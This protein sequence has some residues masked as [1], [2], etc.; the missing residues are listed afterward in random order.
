[1]MNEEPKSIIKDKPLPPSKDFELLKKEGIR[2]SQQLSGAVWTDYNEHDPGVTI[3]ENLCYA[4][5]E[6]GYKTN[7]DI[8]DLLYAKSDN[9]LAN[10]NNV[11]F[12]VS[13]I[14]PCNPTTASDYRKLV[15]DR[16]AGVENAWF[17]PLQKSKTGISVNGLYEVL[18]RTEETADKEAVRQEVI[19]LLQEHRNLCEDFDD[20]RVLNSE[21]IVV[22]ADIRIQ[23]NVV[24]EEI[25]ATVLHRLSELLSPRMSFRNLEEMLEKG[26]TY[27]QIFN[28][29]PPVN[30][31]LED[32]DLE[33]SELT[34]INKLHKS[35]MI[36][37]ISGIEGVIAVTNFSLLI[38]GREVTA[39]FTEL[40]KDTY[41]VLDVNAVLYG[42]DTVQL[43]AGDITYTAD[44][45]TVR[46]S[47]DMMRARSQRSHKRWMDFTPDEGSS[48]KS[49]K[50]IK[51]FY[52]LQ[53]TFPRAYGIGEFG[54]QERASDLRKAQ[55]KQLKG[56]LIFFEQVMVNYLAQLVNFRKLLSV[57]EETEHTWYAQSPDTVP[58]LDAMLAGG[59]EGFKENLDKLMR[60]YDRNT[61]RRNR[62]LDHMLARFGEEFMADAFNAV[63]REANFYTK[64]GFD[65]KSIQ[66]KIKF[67]RNFIDI[68]RNRSKGFNYTADADNAENTAGL[69]KKVSLLFNMP[70]YGHRLLSGIKDDKNVTVEEQSKSSAKTKTGEFT[71]VSDDENVLAE[72][73]AYGTDRNN[74]LI[75]KEKSNYVIRYVNPITHSQTSV[76]QAAKLQACEDALGKLIDRLKSMN[77]DADG[78]HIVEHILLRPVNIRWSF[79]LLG[80][81]SRLLKSETVYNDRTSGKEKFMQDLLTYGKVAK[82]YA[83]V[84][85]EGKKYTLQL[86]GEKGKI[87]AANSNFILK[88]SAEQAGSEALSIIKKIPAGKTSVL[89][90]SI[91]VEQILSKRNAR[92]R[93][94]VFSLTMSV[95][96]PSWSGRFQSDKMKMLFENIV[97]VNAPAHLHIRFHHWGIDQTAEFEQ[98]YRTWLT[99]KAAKN[100]DYNKIDSLSE[101]MLLLLTEE[102]EE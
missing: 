24:G 42:E 17:V 40:E 88:K 64:D 67:L 100:P 54:I 96:I 85:G 94:D 48:D 39:E 10:V 79:H 28:G 61:E 101:K 97:R 87:I 98:S 63:H 33:K 51:Y 68:S 83:V 71:F 29:P 27:E 73:L 11:L 43:Y 66:A 21:K 7:F 31:F 102:E 25:L 60:K 95:I 69:K 5:T 99:E 78:F 80:S 56:Y 47:Y 92:F 22:R 55:A 34:N 53:N 38:G 4:L 12:Q 59:R 49:A 8:T 75:E 65:K 81:I 37:L 45:D 41:P 6:L 72:I 76:Y 15:I 62:F 16:I 58:E 89:A 46:Y 9:G 32:K 74:Y 44:S 23:P 70:N 77:D 93:E 26:Y 36:Q 14:L 91:D 30:G 1:M 86:K 82:N 84:K 18:L 35:R 19:D 3:L 57:D 20:V 13:E 2:L 52:S 50:D 90:K